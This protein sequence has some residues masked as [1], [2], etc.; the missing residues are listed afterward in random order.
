MRLLLLLVFLIVSS[1]IFFGLGAVVIISCVL[2]TRRISRHYR[3]IWRAGIIGVT[4]LVMFA[5][6][7]WKIHRF[8]SPRHFEHQ[9]LH[10]RIVA[11]PLVDEAEARQ[12]AGLGVLSRG[13]QVTSDPVE[14]STQVHGVAK[15]LDVAPD[16]RLAAEGLRLVPH[17]S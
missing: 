4:V 12:P 11:Q 1:P 15:V 6:S 8:V 2:A 16:P 13:R 7:G 14:R 9:I 10:D 3:L 5:V 17:R